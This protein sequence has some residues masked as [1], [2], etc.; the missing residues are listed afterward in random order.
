MEQVR[1]G[2]IIAIDHIRDQ[3]YDMVEQANVQRNQF[4]VPALV[5]KTCDIQQRLWVLWVHPVT[6]TSYQWTFRMYHLAH[7]ELIE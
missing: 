4:P 2:D 6:H 1:E 3:G 5:T 7:M